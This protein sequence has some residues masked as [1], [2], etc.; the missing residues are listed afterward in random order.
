MIF[1]ILFC[2]HSQGPIFISEH[3]PNSTQ[4]DEDKGHPLWSVAPCLRTCLQIYW[5][6]VP[7]LYGENTYFVTRPQDLHDQDYHQLQ[8]ASTWIRNIGSN[9][10]MLRRVIID[11]DPTCPEICPSAMLKH[12]LL[13]LAK[14]V[15]SKK[16]QSG[17]NRELEISFNCRSDPLEDDLDLWNALN[18]D[19]PRM[20]R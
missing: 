11:I 20:L 13:P 3:N 15:W 10:D 9:F 8:W 5:E 4:V 12:Y 19:N 14:L 1:Q 16:R 6:S 7:I 17:K 18:Q 2:F